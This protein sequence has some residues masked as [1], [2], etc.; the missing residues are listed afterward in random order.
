MPALASSGLTLPGGEL[1]DFSGRHALLDVNRP[2]RRN[3]AAVR[4]Q[5][6]RVVEQDDA[7]AEQ[8]PSLLGVTGD[9]A[10]RVTV[11]AVSRRTRGLVRAHRW[12][13]G[14]FAAARTGRAEDRG[15]PGSALIS[16]AMAGWRRIRSR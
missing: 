7:V 5:L 9:G 3:R 10:G 8:A 4:Q 15:A 13:R 11:V 1:V 16:A 12:P 6:A 2:A 14:Q